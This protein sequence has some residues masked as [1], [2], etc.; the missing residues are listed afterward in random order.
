[1]KYMMILLSIIIPFILFIIITERVF[2]AIMKSPSKIE[3]PTCVNCE[4]IEGYKFTL[5]GEQILNKWGYG[6]ECE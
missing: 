1:M 5:Q 2:I 6:I 3:L 4:C